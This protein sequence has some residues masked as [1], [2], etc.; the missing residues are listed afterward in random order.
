MGQGGAPVVLAG[1]TR[2]KLRS[3]AVAYVNGN[4]LQ[5]RSRPQRQHIHIHEQSVQEDPKFSSMFRVIDKIGAISFQT[6][7]KASRSGLSS[8]RMASGVGLP[9]M[10]S[11]MPPPVVFP[12]LAEH[13]STVVI[14]H[15]LGDSGHG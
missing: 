10:F 7:R 8:I 1:R 13:R 2:A 9:A 14:V 5:D 11:N 6:S 12:A 3:P 4:L 15:G